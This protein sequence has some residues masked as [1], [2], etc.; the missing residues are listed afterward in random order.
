MSERREADNR[1]TERVHV[2]F[3]ASIW[4]DVSEEIETGDITQAVQNEIGHTGAQV[5][6]AET[7]DAR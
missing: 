4:L 1:R 2:D 6:D 3:R 7:V 5:I